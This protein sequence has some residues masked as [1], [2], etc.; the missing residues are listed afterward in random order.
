MLAGDAAAAANGM[1]QQ[2][3]RSI[4]AATQER[5]ASGTVLP[6]ST[7]RSLYAAPSAVG[8]LRAVCITRCAVRFVPVMYELS[9]FAYAKSIGPP[10]SC[11]RSPRDRFNGLIVHGNLKCLC[12]NKV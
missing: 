12:V 4:T 3:P 9:T 11:D 2:M 8:E 6:S 1:C 5:L 10:G 7:A